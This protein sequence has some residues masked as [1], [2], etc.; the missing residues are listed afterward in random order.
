MDFKSSAAVV[1][2]ER[3]VAEIFVPFVAFASCV[4]HQPSRL[5][6]FTLA[7]SKQKLNALLPMVVTE[8]G[9]VILVR[10]RQEEN[11]ESQMV[12]TEAGIVT[13]VKEQ[14]LNA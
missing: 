4:H 13:L 2:L 10:L 5:V 3:S 11:A 12:T 1:G 6:K 8:A 7:S 9:I 14:P